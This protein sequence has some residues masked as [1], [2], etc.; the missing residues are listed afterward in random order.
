MITFWNQ[1]EVFIGTSMQNFCKAC[2]IL[3]SNN[4]KYK[5]KINNTNSG[6]IRGNFGSLGENL[7][8]PRTYYI[9][10]NKSDYDYAC[11]LLHNSQL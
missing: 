6:I 11:S 2:S 10:V 8:Y 9:Y 4:I 3:K 1:K 7:N 5:I